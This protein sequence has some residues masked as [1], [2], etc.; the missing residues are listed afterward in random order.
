[1]GAAGLAAYLNEQQSQFLE[2]PDGLFAELVLNDGSKL[3]EVE[4]IAREV[5]EALR[6][7][8]VEVEM[9]VR[10]L[11]LVIDV[12]HAGKTLSLDGGFR[13]AEALP[14]RLF[15]EARGQRSKWT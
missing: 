10:S 12:R 9:V 2:F 8:G 4:R 1:L 13:D 6:K 3:V 7:Q 14:L 5:R 11:W 15:R